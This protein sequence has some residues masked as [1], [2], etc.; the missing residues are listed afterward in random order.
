MVPDVLLQQDNP[1]SLDSV[2][3]TTYDSYTSGEPSSS[4][5]TQITSNSTDYDESYE[6][7]SHENAINVEDEEYED[8]DE[9]LHAYYSGEMFDEMMGVTT[10]S[11]KEEIS[12]ARAYSQ[13]SN[14]SDETVRVVS[15]EGDGTES[16]GDDVMYGDL[17][18]I[19]VTSFLEGME[20]TGKVWAISKD[21]LDDARVI[22]AG[23]EKP[24]GIC[25]DTNN[26]FLYVADP[27][28]T[29]KGYIYQYEIL[30][31]DDEEFV[32]K[33]DEYVIIIEDAAA[34]DCAVDE[35]GNLFF[36]DFFDHEIN[37]VNYSDLWA[38]TKNQEYA[39]YAR[40]EISIPI[41]YPLAIDVVH[42]TKLWYV[43]NLNCDVYG[44]LGSA[45]ADTEYLNDD[46]I[47]SKVHSEFRGWGVAVG[48]S[49]LAYF[50]MS[51]GEVYAFDTMDEEKTY[52]K[53][54]EFFGAPRGICYGEDKVFVADYE[55]GVV[56][57]MGDNNDEETPEG[58]VRIEG[59][60][61]V[62]CVN[63]SNQLMLSLVV[64]LLILIF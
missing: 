61:N 28:F 31:D 51:S 30:W 29:N 19:L 24:T 3:T 7:I 41:S 53:S 32:L 59:S 50:S 63:S 33:T 37:V 16:K 45:S 47:D 6:E 12:L 20:G 48:K 26:N 25:F 1:Y 54:K 57:S 62:F 38:G 2:E 22:I 18:F 42:S 9:I 49:K 44:L 43:N 10:D 46:S 40:T 52:L 34:Y 14:S 15:R 23:L 21:A 5:T 27:G 8:Y 55:R 17:Q 64:L 4:N 39:I 36:V 13:S 35:Y 58:Y 60:Y 11:D 56:Y